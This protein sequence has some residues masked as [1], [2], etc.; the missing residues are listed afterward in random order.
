MEASTSSNS[1]YDDK[2]KE[3]QGLVEAFASVCSTQE[4][5]SAYV[6]AGGNVDVAGEILYQLQRC[7]SK[8]GNGSSKSL[9]VSSYHHI[10]PKL[11]NAE[12][13]SGVLKPKWCSVSMGTVSSVIGKEYVRPSKLEDVS[14]KVIKKPL[15][16]DCKELPLH[17]I[18][19]EKFAPEITVRNDNIHKDVE[20]FLFRMLGDGFQLDKKVIQDVLGLCGYDIK[21]S[22]ER[23]LDLSA[24]TMEKSDDFIPENYT[25]KSPA[26]ECLCN[27]GIPQFAQGIR[28]LS[29]KRE[30]DR[31]DL[32]KEVLNALFTA[33]ERT[34]KA[35]RLIRPMREVRRRKLFGKVVEPLVDTTTKTVNI[36]QE[37]TEEES[38]DDKDSYEVLRK[39]VKEHWITMKEYYKAA[40]DAFAKGDQVRA[41]KL[42]EQGQFFKKKAREADEI[43][44]QKIYETKR[45]DNVSLDLHEHEPR[46][47]RRLLKLHLTSLSG[48]PSIQH[49]KVNIGSAE[50]DSTKG[51]RKRLIAKLL[52]K[53]SIKWTEEEDGKIMFIRV[54][55]VD[56]KR[57]SF[58]NK[59]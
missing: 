34:E 14:Y 31:Y 33:P 30:K 42:L 18:W 51:S 20:E 49:L 6:Q 29:P 28:R 1:S 43:S 55:E 53:E 52:E 22:M 15:K 9:A 37:A 27:N 40:V 47:A 57:L 26:I 10:I 5:S 13:N 11:K 58:A 24:P 56:P 39:A 54:D 48:I 7:T 12:R 19:D 46:E 23:L 44:T 45:D 32:Q 36:E 50:E 21:K 25:G 16:L 59:Q 4:I 35:P 38:I 17:E 41:N 3:M 8:N 2:G